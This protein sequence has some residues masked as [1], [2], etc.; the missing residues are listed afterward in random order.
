MNGAP[1]ARLFLARNFNVDCAVFWLKFCCKFE[2]RNSSAD[3]ERKRH[4]V[5]GDADRNA[6][7]QPVIFR[8]HVVSPSEWFALDVLLAH[9]FASEAI[10]GPASKR[11]RCFSASRY[12]E[13]EAWINSL[14]AGMKTS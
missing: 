11:F 4:R 3:P 14:M 12:Q 7:D 9:R 1:L 5:K 8:V 10:Y 13:Q 2:Q 6:V